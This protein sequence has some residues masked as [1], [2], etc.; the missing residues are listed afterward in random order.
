M[1]PLWTEVMEMMGGTFKEMRDELY[2][3]T[4]EEEKGEEGDGGTVGGPSSLLE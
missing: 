3:E 1:K 4:D 2:G